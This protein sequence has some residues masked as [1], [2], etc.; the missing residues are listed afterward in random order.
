MRQGSVRQGARSH[1]Q[2]ELF[3]FQAEPP[4]PLQTDTVRDPQGSVPLD[5]EF[6]LME[7]KPMLSPGGNV[8]TA[9]MRN[10]PIRIPRNSGRVTDLRGEEVCRCSG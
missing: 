10:F 7:Q 8:R 2:K 1:S 9:D 6:K 3:I 4:P 5:G